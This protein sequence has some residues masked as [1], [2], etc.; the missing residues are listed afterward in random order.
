MKRF[1]RSCGYP[2]PQK[3]NHNKKGR[4]DK[5]KIS[6][7]E[8]TSQ[9]LNDDVKVEVTEP[10]FVY[11]DC[12]P[13]KGYLILLPLNPHFDNEI[14]SLSNNKISSNMDHKKSLLFITCL[15]KDEIPI[16]YPNLITPR[17]TIKIRL[18]HL[19]VPEDIKSCPLHEFHPNINEIVM[20]LVSGTFVHLIDKPMFSS[21][22]SDKGKESCDFRN[23][24]IDEENEVSDR[25]ICLAIGCLIYSGFSFENSIQ[26]VFTLLGFMSNNQPDLGNSDFGTKSNLKDSESKRLDL[27]FLDENV[28]LGSN[29]INLS[30]VPNHERYHNFEYFNYLLKYERYIEDTFP[31]RQ[32]SQSSPSKSI[33]KCISNDNYQQYGIFS[34]RCQSLYS[35][36]EIYDFRNKSPEK[37]RENHT[38]LFRYNSTS[39]L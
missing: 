29:N 30:R 20:T 16:Y 10:N 34:P 27:T 3:F 8:E 37:G 36:K 24:I 28:M 26:H 14:L 31:S 23:K 33:T 22:N 32:R 9:E 13:F 12:L 15:T 21:K 19:D 18:L 25:I 1:L 7:E 35:S 11:L 17:E 6:L 4:K 2:I 39:M 38:S 5:I